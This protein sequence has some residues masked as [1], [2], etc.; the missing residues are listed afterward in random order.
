MPHDTTGL[1][2]SLSSAQCVA[3]R[4]TAADVGADVV[5]WQSMK[6][7]VP[8]VQYSK[9]AVEA[10]LNN[11]QVDQSAFQDVQWLRQC[12]ATDVT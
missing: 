4:Y 1:L 5:R 7:E 11:L 10:C 12:I 9:Q 2:I 3:K 8:V 6:V